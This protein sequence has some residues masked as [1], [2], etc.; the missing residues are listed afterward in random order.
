MDIVFAKT[1]ADYNWFYSITIAIRQEQNWQINWYDLVQEGN[2]SEASKDWE[3]EGDD[4]IEGIYA[5]WEE[6]TR[7][8]GDS[9]IPSFYYDHMIQQLI[10][11]FY[12]DEDLLAFYRKDSNDYEWKEI[13]IYEGKRGLLGFLGDYRRW[14]GYE[15]VE[16][17]LKYGDKLALAKWLTEE[18][19]SKEAL[20]VIMSD[21]GL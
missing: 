7:K 16:L 3:W 10:W 6:I 17:K 20:E 11:G 4:V 8:S 18:E 21:L 12:D 19:D 1:S 14:R 5:L 15:P 2:E 9:R 13:R